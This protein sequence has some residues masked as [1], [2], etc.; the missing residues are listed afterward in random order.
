MN[1]ESLSLEGLDF[2][3]L[4]LSRGSG[5]DRARALKAGLRRARPDDRG[6]RAGLGRVRPDDRGLRITS[7]LGRFLRGDIPYTFAKHRY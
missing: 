2:G 3:S 1:F 5:G 4:T 7:V 6:V